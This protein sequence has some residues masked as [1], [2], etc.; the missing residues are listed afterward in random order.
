MYLENEELVFEEEDF[1][2]YLIDL[3]KSFQ[4]KFGK[5]D[6]SQVQTVGQLFDVIMN[7]MSYADE[8]YCSSQQA[9]Y[10]LRTGIEKTFGKTIKI[11]TKISEIFHPKTRK[12][13][14]RLQKETNLN[15]PKLELNQVQSGFYLIIVLTAIGS[16]IIMLLKFKIGALIFG[17]TCLLASTTR[18]FSSKLPVTN[19]RELVEKLVEMNY[20]RVM[21]GK[22]NRVEVQQLLKKK[23]AEMADVSVQQVNAALKLGHI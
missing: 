16:F 7:K 10:V 15:L 6:F 8:T 23:L 9:F 17:I 22:N 1:E 4:I 14:S 21:K 19:V 20:T 11:N 12:N 2:S 18:Y 5:D 13:W 3:E